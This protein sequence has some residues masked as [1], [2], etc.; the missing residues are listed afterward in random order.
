MSQIFKSL[1]CVFALCFLAFTA[2][3][4]A[5]DAQAQSSCEEVRAP[6]KKAGAVLAGLII[7]SAELH[8]INLSPK[9]VNRR[10]AL[11]TLMQMYGFGLSV[12]HIVD[13]DQVAPEKRVKLCRAL[14]QDYLD[15]T[16]LNAEQARVESL[17]AAASQPTTQADEMLLKQNA[18]LASKRH[19]TIKPEIAARYPALVNQILT[20]ASNQSRGTQQELNELE[21]FGAEKRAKFCKIYET[22]RLSLKKLNISTPMEHALADVIKINGEKQ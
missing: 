4:G 18:E 13:L 15:M 1:C 9:E 11:E 20:A 10:H 6:G 3:A 7:K 2:Q 17:C 14:K 21:E 5:L 16:A 22:E 19:E 8:G 12:E